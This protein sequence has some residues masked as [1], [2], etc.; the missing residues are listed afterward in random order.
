[1]MKWVVIILAILFLAWET[2][3][4]FISEKDIKGSLS[5]T[6]TLL[7]KKPLEDTNKIDSVKVGAKLDTV[8]KNN[9][10]LPKGTID[11]KNVQPQQVVDYAKTLIGT[12]YHYAST[13]PNVGFDCS[14]FVTHVFHHFDIGVPRSSIDFTNVGKEVSAAQAKSGDLIL[15]TG[16]DST[17]R[18][19][20]HMGIVISN[21]DT[22]RFIHSSSGKAHGVTITALNG[23]YRSRYVKTIR[24]F[25][26]NN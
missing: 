7:A 25:P 15:F 19:V 24:V 21:T 22:L 26:Q 1:M 6:D 12:P 2:T 17:E 16:T 9:L 20:G 8:A 13:D 18:F 3:S 11:T 23:Y 10:P 14:G 5:V 4:F